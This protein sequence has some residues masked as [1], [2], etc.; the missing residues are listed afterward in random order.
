MRNHGAAGNRGP[1]L[2]KLPLP[3]VRTTA[4]RAMLRLGYDLRRVHAPEWADFSD[5]QL[6]LCAEVRTLTHASRER[7]VTLAD[8]VAYIVRRGI[9]GDFVERGVW[10]GGSSIVIVKTLL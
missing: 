6:T 9:A 8:A 10:L 4:R 3:R 1:Q 7:I 2:S 5:E